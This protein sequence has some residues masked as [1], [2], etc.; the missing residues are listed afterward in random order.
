ME[1]E[2]VELKQKHIEAWSKELP[3]AEETP[4]PVYNGAVVRAALK[5]GWFKDCK[6]KPEEV[7]EMSP[8]VVRKLAEKIV[9]EYADLM[10]VSPE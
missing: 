2:F 4:M 3:K 1:Y 9:K 5:A 6:V 10:K 8:A 7:G